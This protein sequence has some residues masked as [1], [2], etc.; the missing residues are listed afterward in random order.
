MQ[1]HASPRFLVVRTFRCHQH[2]DCVHD[3]A[4]VGS[5]YVSFCSVEFD[6]QDALQHALQSVSFVS[7]MHS[8]LLFGKLQTLNFV[9]VRMS[10]MDAIYACQGLGFDNFV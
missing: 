7:R 6:Q 9:S 8:S 5:A 2:V 3:N 1:Y 10:R 4:C